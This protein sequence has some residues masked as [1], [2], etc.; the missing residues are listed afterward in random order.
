[1]SPAAKVTNNGATSLSAGARLLTISDGWS[2]RG[3]TPVIF[4][5]ISALDKGL[6]I[7][8]GKSILQSK[9]CSMV[10]I[11][12][13]RSRRLFQRSV[14]VQKYLLGWDEI[15]TAIWRAGGCLSLEAF[16]SAV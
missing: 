11:A 4:D 1:M 16:I 5:S 13:P 8:R 6:S 10:V 2:S 14:L 12:A 7:G 15:F 9:L 3:L